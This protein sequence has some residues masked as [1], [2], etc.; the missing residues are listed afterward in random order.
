MNRYIDI[1]YDIDF[2]AMNRN[3]IMYTLFML[4]NRDDERNEFEKKIYKSNRSRALADYE[5]I[6]GQYKEIIDRFRAV[7]KNEQMDI[8]AYYI[9]KQKTFDIIC[10]NLLTRNEL[11]ILLWIMREYQIT[12]QRIRIADNEVMQSL[13]GDSYKLYRSMF[14]K[15][16]DKFI[17]YEY[18]DGSKL[19]VAYE[20]HRGRIKIQLD[21]KHTLRRR[22]R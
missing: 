6:Y 13:F 21:V 18:D 11:K 15:T 4:S 8:P 7:Q 3:E 17:S 22:R 20:N 19:V 16:L 2:N 14:K 9:M 10:T 1:S 12:Y 5:K